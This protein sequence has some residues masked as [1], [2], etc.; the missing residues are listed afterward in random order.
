MP[1]VFS[2]NNCPQCLFTKKKMDALGI[3]YE[4]VNMSEH[5]EAAD[6]VRALGYQSAPV[7]ITE[8]EHWSGFR[9]DKISSLALVSA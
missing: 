4:E 3:Q 1:R 6:E 7:V 8:S 2:L 9:P 5:P